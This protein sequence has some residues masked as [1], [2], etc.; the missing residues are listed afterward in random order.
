MD[1]YTW[2]DYMSAQRLQL[3]KS[4]TW[5]LIVDEIAAHLDIKRDTVYKWLIR[6]QMPRHKLGRLGKYRI[7]DVDQWVLNGSS[8]RQHSRF[9]EE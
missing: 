6:K 4:D 5:W 9:E 8:A 7:Q 1:E 2:E 3:D